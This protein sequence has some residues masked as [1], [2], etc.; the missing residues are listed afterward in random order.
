MKKTFQSQL[1]VSYQTKIKTIH[2]EPLKKPFFRKKAF[3]GTLEEQCLHLSKVS[4]QK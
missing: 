2:R 3:S 4:T 1:E